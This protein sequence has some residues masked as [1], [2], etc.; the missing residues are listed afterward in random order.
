MPRKIFLS[1]LVICFYTSLYAQFE[2]SKLAPEYK[3]YSWDE[4]PKLH[5]LSD[6]E[7]KRIEVVIKDKR[8]LEYF[9]DSEDTLSLYITRHFIVRVNSD[10]AIEENNTVYIQLGEG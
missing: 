3:S 1:A 9:F 5:D 6:A 2:T 4:S 8:I 7:R 10:K